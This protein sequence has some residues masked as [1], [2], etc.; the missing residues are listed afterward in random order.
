METRVQGASSH[1]GRRNSAA[2]NTPRLTTNNALRNEAGQASHQGSLG[3]VPT[4]ATVS[5][6]TAAMSQP[7]TWAR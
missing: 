2:A 6:P 5:T 1:Q 3:S 4:Y 7:R